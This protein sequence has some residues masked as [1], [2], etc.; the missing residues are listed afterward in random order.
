MS[1]GEE[2]NHRP[3]V[4]PDHRGDRPGAARETWQPPRG[5]AGARRRT[6]RVVALVTGTLALAATVTGLVVLA[7]RS[8]PGREETAAS[9]RAS[10]RPAAPA[11]PEGGAPAPTTT[12]ESQDQDA[13]AYIDDMRLGTCVNEVSDSTLSDK[14]SGVL[15]LASC[16]GPHDG[17]VLARFLLPAG[18]WPGGGRLRALAV[19]GCRARLAP[20]FERSPVGE[21]LASLAFVP[22]REEW[23]DDRL[24]ICVAVHR[25]VGPLV[26]PVDPEQAGPAQTEAGGAPRGGGR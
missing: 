3:W 21:R 17:E 13:V 8:A 19:E 5:R 23:P 16:A 22:L 11:S 2:N 4:S 20:I 7:P 1:S 6:R 14:N 9:T 10:A 26:G 15:P 12:E 18:G 25:Q 24:V